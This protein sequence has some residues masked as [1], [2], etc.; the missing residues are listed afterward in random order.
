MNRHVKE[1]QTKCK[2][3]LNLFRCITSTQT[4]ADRAT[5]LRLYK[6]IVLPIIEYGAAMY[7]GGK[8]PGLRKLEAVQNTFLR[9]ALGA[10]K[11][12]PVISLQVEANIPPLYIRR[13]DLVMR[14]YAKIQHFPRTRIISGHKSSPQITFFLPWTTGK[15]NRPYNSIQG[16]EIL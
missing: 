14:Y 1:I 13:M 6:T 16:Q 2:R 4:G 7:S 5:L 12:S 11:T 15:K 9:L 3:R 8:A 10:M